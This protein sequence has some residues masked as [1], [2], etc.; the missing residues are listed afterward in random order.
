[1]IWAYSFHS[2]SSESSSAVLPNAIEALA[3][4][5]ATVSA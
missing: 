5:V 4:V 3:N 1:M 2:M